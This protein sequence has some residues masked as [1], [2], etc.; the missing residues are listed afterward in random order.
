MS[1]SGILTPSTQSIGVI[2][3]NKLDALPRSVQFI[4][5]ALFVFLFFGIHNILQEAMTNTEGFKFGVMLGWMEVLGV[6]LCN[7]IE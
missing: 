1:L 3:S 6:T 7:G 4:I 5:L 2:L